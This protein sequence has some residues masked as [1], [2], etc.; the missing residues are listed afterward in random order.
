M[1]DTPVAPQVSPP[2]STIPHSVQTSVDVSSLEGS[3]IFWTFVQV[4]AIL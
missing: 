3:R 2:V 4:L 1:I